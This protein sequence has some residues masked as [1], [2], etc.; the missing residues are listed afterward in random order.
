MRL[1]VHPRQHRDYNYG[2]NEF[3][4]ADFEGPFS[5]N[6]RALAALPAPASTA[7]IAEGRGSSPTPSAAAPDQ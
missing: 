6:F 1:D 2:V 7:G 4:N 5:N 3:V